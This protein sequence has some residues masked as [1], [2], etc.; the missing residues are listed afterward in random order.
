M[1]SRYDLVGQTQVS[2]QVCDSSVGQIA[3]VV[4]PAEGD[5]NVFTR[6]ERLHQHENL[7]VGWSLN[8]RVCGRLGVLLHDADSLLEEVAEDSDAV[9]LRDEHVDY[10]ICI[11]SL[12][13]LC[14][15]EG[16]AC[17]ILE[18]KHENF[19]SRFC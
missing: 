16:F 14:V 8:V 12:D 7:Q 11:S 5:A 2:S 10:S 3:V 15:P 17:R 18:Q 19:S 6:L 4:L 9:F 13:V 1:S